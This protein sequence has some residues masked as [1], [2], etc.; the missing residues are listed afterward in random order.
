MEKGFKPNNLNKKDGLAPDTKIEPAKSGEYA[1]LRL[2]LEKEFQ[3]RVAA[4]KKILAELNIP[5]SDIVLA[6]PVL[7]RTDFGY[8]ADIDFIFLG[9]AELRNELYQKM[10]AS[11]EV[12]A[13]IIDINPVRLS[14]IKNELPE[15]YQFIMETRA[16]FPAGDAADLSPGDFYERQSELED[17]MRAVLLPQEKEILKEQRLKI[18]QSF[19]QEVKTRVPILGEHFSGSMMNDSQRF[20]LNS[21]LDID[22]LTNIPEA[23]PSQSNAYDW[24]HIYLKWKYARDYGIKVD[25]GDTDLKFAQNM[26]K[27][28]SKFIEFYKTQY[29]V[30]ITGNF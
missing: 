5:E 16:R 14:E 2:V 4:L 17:K 11:H 18:G 10:Y 27:H 12:L 19:I 21:D 23:D 29:N 30:D 13:H 15:L 3:R 22:F 6:P 28:D 9:T 20:G 1:E 7:D 8:V 24:L 26:A 25:V